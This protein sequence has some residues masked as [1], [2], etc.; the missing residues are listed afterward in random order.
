MNLAETIHTL[1][2][3][4]QQLSMRILKRLS[5]LAP[6]QQAE[7]LAAWRSIAPG[8]RREIAHAMVEL[9]ED[10]VELRFDEAWFWLL[11][12][13]QAEVRCS[14]VEGLWE[15]T[16]LRALR[17]TLALLR[18]DPV[19]DVRAAAAAALSRFAYLV[20]LDELPD[21][22]D[23]LRA[24]LLHSARNPQEPLEVQR[25]ALESAG[26]FGDDDVQRA[27]QQAYDVDEQ[28]LRESAL[29]AMGRSML[30]RWLP[31]IKRELGS[32]SPALRYEA[33]RAAGEMAEDARALLSSIIPLLNDQDSEVA[34]MAIWALGQIGGEAAQ[35]A[36]RQVRASQDT[37]RSQAASEALEELLL[38]DRLM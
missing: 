5:N 23:E 12:D 15:D 30:P 26:Y 2:M 1:G 35:R 6:Q 28:L 11:D 18:N 17:R 19:P 24:A 20:V 37:S 14:A 3:P 34:L 16:S 36:L 7:F 21:A 32:P 29:V 33:A 10:N 9:A 31:I 13:E 27:V 25:R 8:R 38:E 22:A 4:S